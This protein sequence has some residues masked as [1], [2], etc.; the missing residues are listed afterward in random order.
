M[1]GLS[2]LARLRMHISRAAQP[3]ATS[4]SR[5]QVES[6][7]RE[8][9]KSTL[10]KRR[11]RN[12]SEQHMYDV[13]Y[14]A[15]FDNEP[16]YQRTSFPT[17]LPAADPRQHKTPAIEGLEPPKHACP[18][19]SADASLLAASLP[20][21][22]LVGGCWCWPPIFASPTEASC[23]PLL[24]PTPLLPP[25]PSIPSVDAEGCWPPFRPLLLLGLLAPSRA[26]RREGSLA[27]GSMDC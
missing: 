26:A 15:Y 21:P 19:L 16:T 4:G 18:H 1:V 2:M 12:W 6:T 14:G 20:T 11:R 23:V 3:N 24:V 25:P 9:P 17:T 8:A 5:V 27:C 22:V 13:Q 7:S 10:P